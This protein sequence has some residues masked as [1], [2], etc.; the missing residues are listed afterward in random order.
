MT[1]ARLI[2]GDSKSSSDMYYRTRFWVGDPVPFFEIDGKTGLV[3]NNLE[4]D[5][6]KKDAQVDE[7][8][9]LAEYMG[10]AKEAGIDAPG[11][12]DVMGVL[13]R[14]RGVSSIQVPSTFPLLHADALRES[15]FDVSPV[16]GAFYSERLVKNAEEIEHIA[17]AQ[18]MTEE[19]MAIAIEMIAESE[20]NA[21]G[22]LQ[23]GGDT[24]TSERVRTEVSIYFMQRGYDPSA[25]IVAGGDQGVDPHERGSGPLRA[26]ECIVLDI[27]PRNKETGYWGDMT[28]TVLR[29]EATD[30]QQRQYDTVL[31]AQE[32]ACDMVMAG[33]TGLEIHRHVQTVFD[34][35]GY[36]TGELD[37]RMQG[38]FHGTGHGVGLDIHEGPSVGRS[39][40]PL[41]PG[42]VVTIEPGLYY[43]AS[44]G[45]RI[46]DIVVVEEGGNRN[47]NSYPKE[48]VV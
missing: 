21:D 1:E 42:M 45:I 31:Q 37:G 39:D 13:F 33:V 14:E 44:G 9:S 32:E 5:R 19:G 36:E 10:K 34:E 12:A 18:A 43:L 16:K 22:V 7:V 29:G 41:E 20:P 24:L 17:A 4:I 27:F 25:I 3:C 6:A 40:A 46:E 35:A 11:Y 15:G 47:L 8:I 38:F 28:R 26:N 30:E 2:I 23:Y 48:F